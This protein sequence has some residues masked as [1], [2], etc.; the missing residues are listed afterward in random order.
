MEQ[1]DALKAAALADPVTAAWAAMISLALL[2]GVMKIILFNSRRKKLLAEY[3]EL[4]TITPP[5]ATGRWH[6]LRLGLIL[7]DS[8][9]VSDPPT[10]DPPEGEDA[11]VGEVAREELVGLRA[12]WISSSENSNALDEHAQDVVSGSTTG[13]SIVD[14]DETQ[15]DQFDKR[16]EREGGKRGVMQVSLMWDNYND[17]DLHL[18]TPS[19]ERIYF[20]NRHSDCGGELDVDMNVKPTSRTPIEN[21]FW[22]ELPPPS[23]YKIAIH[24][25]SRHRRWRTKD[26]T[27]FK[28]RVRIF[29]DSIELA[30]KLSRGDPM[31][32][33][34]TFV[35]AEPK[36]DSVEG[37]EKSD[38]DFVIEEK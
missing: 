31:K 22:E 14:E 33:I 37:D 11:L 23:K 29:E 20:N 15:D 9:E 24:H 38:D 28:V 18:F 26:P 25:Y 8:T 7:S 2:W 19:G 12:Q 17:L 27:P 21:V 3:G 1:L 30:G 16:L 6:P 35:V 5:T 13:V 32:F 4:E 34:H 10:E 36:E